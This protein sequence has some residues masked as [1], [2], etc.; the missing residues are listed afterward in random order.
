MP[1]RT[2]EPEIASKDSGEYWKLVSKHQ[3]GP[4][5]Y[6]V[7]LGLH[8]YDTKGLIEHIEEGFSYA[9]L[10]RV[11]RN[12]DVSLR[13]LAELLQMSV[14]TLSRRKEKGKLE[15]DESDRLVR[16]CRVLGKALEL[17]EGDHESARNWLARKQIGLGGARPLDL[18]RSEVGAREVEELIGR[19][20]HGVV[21]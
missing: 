5:P 21:S 9:A 19:L 20:E 8:A 18:I 4:H 6:V 12:I 17:F 14:R 2:K 16:L 13:E 15:P 10:E 1:T 3:Q 11:Q 7:F